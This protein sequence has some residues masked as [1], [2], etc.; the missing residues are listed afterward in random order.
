MA[1]LQKRGVVR[2]SVIGLEG[3]WHGVSAVAI[4]VE[5]TVVL[6]RSA[7][8]ES[9]VSGVV[10]VWVRPSGDITGSQDDEWSA[11]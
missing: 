9:A 4:C 1:R 10:F 2:A 11:L 6:H 8:S 3:D 5:Q 7:G